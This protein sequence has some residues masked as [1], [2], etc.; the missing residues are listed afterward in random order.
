MSNIIDYLKLRGN[1]SSE[2]NPI[3]E[4]Q[5][6]QQQIFLP[7]AKKIKKRVMSDEKNKGKTNRII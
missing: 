1:L 5:Q 3:N 7:M 6:K 4:I 2:I